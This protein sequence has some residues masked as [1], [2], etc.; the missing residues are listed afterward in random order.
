MINLGVGAGNMEMARFFL[1]IG[2]M[3]TGT[4]ALQRTLAQNYDE[5]MRDGVLYP[6]TARF[7]V[8][9]GAKLV[10]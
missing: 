1:H 4:T 2:L 5:L 10:H 6:K 7:D 9:G 3:K 8:K